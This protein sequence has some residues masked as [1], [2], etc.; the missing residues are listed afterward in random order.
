M[1]V[2]SHV[3][4]AL[5]C[6]VPRRCR[7]DAATLRRSSSQRSG[8]AATRYR[9]RRGP[10]TRSKSRSAGAVFPCRRYATRASARCT[11]AANADASPAANVLS[12]RTPGAAKTAQ[13][14]RSIVTRHGC[15]SAPLRLP[16]LFVL[17]GR[18]QNPGPRELE[19]APRAS[20]RAARSGQLFAR[21]VVEQ[22]L[23]TL[24]KSCVLRPPH[25]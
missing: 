25:G 12:A 11:A 17:P 4:A 13:A 18:Q 3:V 2:W 9:F 23:C 8:A 19:L 16:C 22:P 10:C 15:R 5:R 21:A 24:L 14:R 20:S 6:L 7:G 1:P